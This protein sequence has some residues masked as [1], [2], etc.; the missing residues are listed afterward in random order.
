MIWKMLLGWSA[1]NL[2]SYSV[3]PNCRFAS[4]ASPETNWPVEEIRVCRILERLAKNRL[5]WK[6]NKL[7]EALRYKKIQD[8]AVFQRSTSGACW[9]QMLSRDSRMAA[10]KVGWQG[11]KS[12]TALLDALRSCSTAKTSNFHKEA[13]PDSSPCRALST[14]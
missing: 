9:E 1:P 12:C 11:N 8:S 5:A 4:T 7:L 2:G 6:L 10:H 13:R 3:A 14:I